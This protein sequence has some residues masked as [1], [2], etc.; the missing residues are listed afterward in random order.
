[1]DTTQVSRNQLPLDYITVCN[2]IN[3][4]VLINIIV[5]NRIFYSETYSNISN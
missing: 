1:M 2:D 5:T 3:I 4:I